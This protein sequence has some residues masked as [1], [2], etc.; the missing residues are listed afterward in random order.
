MR[1]TDPEGGNKPLQ[2]NVPTGGVRLGGGRDLISG[3]L[4]PCM[5]TAESKLMVVLI[6]EGA[7]EIQHME[8]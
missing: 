3:P 8:H 2:V 5:D 1:K 7:Y 6:T 4:L